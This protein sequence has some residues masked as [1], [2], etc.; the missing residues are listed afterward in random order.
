MIS[1]PGQYEAGYLGQPTSQVRFSKLNQRY[2]CS[3]RSLQVNQRNETMGGG[4]EA[5]ASRQ[6]ST[7]TTS[8][9]S[10]TGYSGEIA[11]DDLSTFE[12]YKFQ[13]SRDYNLDNRSIS[14]HSSLRNHM[15]HHDAWLLNGICEVLTSP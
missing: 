1:H 3:R 12:D 4:Y 6:K 8:F 5:D 11:P 14:S 9:T 15:L 10:V 13:F 2:T 7:N